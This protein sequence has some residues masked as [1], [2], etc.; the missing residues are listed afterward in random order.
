[1]DSNIATQKKEPAER[2]FDVTASKEASRKLSSSAVVD[3]MEELTNQKGPNVSEFSVNL[4][5]VETQTDLTEIIDN[6]KDL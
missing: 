3:V 2:N 6:K 4:K 1:M 5:N